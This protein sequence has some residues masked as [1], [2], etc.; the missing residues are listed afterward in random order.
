MNHNVGARVVLSQNDSDNFCL[1]GRHNYKTI[2]YKNGVAN[3]S[4]TVGVKGV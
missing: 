4:H 3:F 2:I 1:T